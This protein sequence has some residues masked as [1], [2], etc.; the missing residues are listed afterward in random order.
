MHEPPT[1]RP[2][3]VL[4][5]RDPRD[6]DAWRQFVEVYAP[7][8]YRFAR[9]CRLQDA[10]AAEVT[11]DV[12]K[13]VARACRRFD[14]DP[15][16]GSFRS[17]LF[18]VVRSK[19]SDFR[20]REDRPDRAT[21]DADNLDQLPARD[22]AEA[23]WEREYERRLFDWAAERVRPDFSESSWRAFWLTAVEGQSGKEVAAALGLSAGAVY[24]AKSRILA[25]LK[26]QIRHL[27][28]D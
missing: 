16:R 12:L 4:R 18:A 24:I 27:H 8:V 26:E 17:W 6:R 9:R 3:L 15:R 20:A 2:S 19:L 13:A 11:Q 1:T 10:D 25:R 7:L 28:E 22:D 23:V 21:G 5:I 14:Y